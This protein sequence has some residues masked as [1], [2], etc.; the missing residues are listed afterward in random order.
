[1]W[2]QI[3]LFFCVVAYT[4]GAQSILEAKVGERVALTI[5][6]GVVTWK[7]L[8]KGEAE[9]T[10]KHCKPSNKEAGCKEF[11][12]KD[13]EKALP[14]SSAK[15]LAN[16]TLVITSFKATDAGTYSSPDLKPKVTKH[17]DGSESAVAPSEIVVVL[18]E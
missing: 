12:T 8:R 18:K 3:L 7:R 11:V 14:E 16:G 4:F 9:E 15:V 1:M 5:G 6:D 2:S 13:G 17:K 10:I